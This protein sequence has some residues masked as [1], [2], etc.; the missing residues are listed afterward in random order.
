[1]D[2]KLIWIILILIIILLLSTQTAETTPTWETPMQV[3][4]EAPAGT[5]RVQA[6][7]NGQLANDTPT[8]TLSHAGIYDEYPSWWMLVE[9]PCKDGDTIA[10]GIDYWRANETITFVPEGFAYVPMLT[11]APP[12]TI[13]Y[14]PLIG[15]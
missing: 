6:Y 13:L 7:C 4:G 11:K 1:M 8:Y 14:F 12:T 2:N 15:K 10:F 9:E 3:S 5:K